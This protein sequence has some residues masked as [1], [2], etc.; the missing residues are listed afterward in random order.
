MSY[1][2][3]LFDE[4]DKLLPEVMFTENEDGFFYYDAVTGVGEPIEQSWIDQATA[5]LA[6]FQVSYALSKLREERNK[7]LS[8][9][10]YWMFSDTATPTQAQLDYRQELRDITDT[11]TSLDDVVWPTKP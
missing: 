6:T 11:Y 4:L 7:R 8:E 10:D 5:N 9:T 3:N 2:P 1:T